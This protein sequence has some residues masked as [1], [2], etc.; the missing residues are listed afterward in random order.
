MEIRQLKYAVRVAETQHFGRAAELEHIAPSVLSTQIR[1]L[2]LELGVTLFERNS[3]Q[4]SVTPVGAHFMREA[5]S[6]LESL[7]TLQTETRSLGRVTDYKLGIGYFGEALGELTH[8]LFGSFSERHPG[9]RLSFTELF[10]NNQLEALHTRQVDVAFMR[11][12]VDDPQLEVIP[13]YQEPVHAAVSARSEFADSPRLSVNDILDQPFAIAAGGTPSSWS[14]YWSL[15]DQRGEPSR[16]GA[17]VTTVSE[18][19]SAIAYSNTIDTVPASAARAIPHPG[20]S[21]VPINDAGLSA[22]AL[23][24]RKD[25]TNPMISPL[26]D[27]VTE[28]V[29]QRISLLNG[30]EPLV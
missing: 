10:M 16:I 9:T 21:F 4:V 6:I 30:A 14:G 19:F 1:R 15:D 25:S 26:L 28:L 27:C 2:E 18:S 12:P 8:L 29:R 7:S 13:L 17:E 24:F 22:L 23:V 11:L 5:A 20:V 3:H